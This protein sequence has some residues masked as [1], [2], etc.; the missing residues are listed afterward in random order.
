MQGLAIPSYW[1]ITLE[2]EM[3]GLEDS[4]VPLAATSD[5][6]E[7]DKQSC[8]VFWN[9]IKCISQQPDNQWS[10]HATSHR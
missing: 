5:L 6:V 1:R 3:D 9:S 2:P 10:K 4:N 7:A 8:S